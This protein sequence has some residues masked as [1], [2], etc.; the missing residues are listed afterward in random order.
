MTWECL[1][2]MSRSDTSSYGPYG[3]MESCSF[4]RPADGHEHTIASLGVFCFS[5][6]AR[7]VFNLNNGAK[8]NRFC[9]G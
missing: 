9:T 5:R 1:E 2:Q 8:F 7:Y 4:A 6:Y 3:M